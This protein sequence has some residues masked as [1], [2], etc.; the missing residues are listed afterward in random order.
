M[1]SLYQVAGL[2]RQALWKA[3]QRTQYCETV[4]SKVV[5]ECRK[6]RKAHKRMSCRRM[7][8]K[9]KE[10]IPVGRDKFESIGFK[11]GF[12]VHRKRNTHRTTIATTEKPYPNLVEGKILTGINQV[13]QSDIFYIKAENKDH[14]GISIIDVYSRKLLALHVSL[15]MSADENVIALKDTLKIRCKEA[16][17]GCILHSDRGSQYKSQAMLEQLNLLEMI[18]SM[19]LIA[20]ENSYAERVQGTLKYEYLFEEELTKKNIKSYMKKIKDLYNNER[21][22]SELGNLTPTQFEQYVESLPLNERPI[23]NIYKWTHPMLNRVPN[24]NPNN[25]V[26]VII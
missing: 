7:Y 17:K 9:C 4:S 14:Y 16:L 18:P 22:H 24:V 21:P 2:S 19:G 13:L 3:K 11:N 20:Q 10:R 15:S 5:S 26:R 8:V 25:K 6:I 23:M 12:K 1:E